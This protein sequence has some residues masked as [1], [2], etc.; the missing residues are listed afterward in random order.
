MFSDSNYQPRSK[1]KSLVNCIACVAANF[2][3]DAEKVGKAVQGMADRMTPKFA[4]SQSSG[5]Y[6]TTSSNVLKEKNTGISTSSSIRTPQGS[7]KTK[8]QTTKSASQ[9]AA[10]NAAAAY[11][12]NKRKQTNAMCALL[13]SFHLHVGLSTAFHLASHL[14]AGGNSSSSNANTPNRSTRTMTNGANNSNKKD[15][16]K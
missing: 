1:H 3:I 12:K 2:Y 7:L 8:Q 5:A 6:K 14:L 15:S 13:L 9:L 16:D 4:S 10:E 11:A